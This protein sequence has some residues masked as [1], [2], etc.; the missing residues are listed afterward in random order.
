[1]KVISSETILPKYSN[2]K[3]KNLSTTFELKTKNSIPSDNSPHKITI[4]ISNMPIEFEYTTTPKIL[5][6]VYL[7]GKTINNNDYPLL[8]GEINIFVDNDFVNRTYINN[9]VS[10]DSLELALGI[11]ESIQAEK[12][13]KNRFVESKGLFSGSKQI[14]YDYEIQITNN[15]K[16]EEKIWVYD[17]LP[18]AMNE[19]IKIELITPSEKEEGLNKNKEIVWQLKLSPG[20]KKIL[21]LKFTVE[22]PSDISVY[23][24]E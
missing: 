1:M 21:L 20:E 12:I 4:A 24:L 16:T 3:A 5:P 18:V 19:G 13:L 8:E 15:R 6:K 10:S 11:D 9:I 23:G 2:V 14:T 7:K 22:F 17:Q